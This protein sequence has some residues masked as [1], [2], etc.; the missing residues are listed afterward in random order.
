[1]DGKGKERVPGVAAEA[2]VGQCKES[3]GPVAGNDLY[4]ARTNL[5]EDSAVRK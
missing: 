5:A 3:R 1:M 2:P 4:R